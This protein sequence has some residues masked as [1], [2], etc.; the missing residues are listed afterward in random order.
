[1]SLFL[2][3]GYSFANIKSLCL[4]HMAGRDCR[5]SVERALPLLRGWDSGAGSGSNDSKQSGESDQFFGNQ[6]ASCT[7]PESDCQLDT[8]ITVFCHNLAALL[9]LG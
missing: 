1:M 2:V 9:Q 4:T 7:S 6:G 5:V 3:L 8:E